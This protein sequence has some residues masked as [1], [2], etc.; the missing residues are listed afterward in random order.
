[1]RASLFSL[2]KEGKVGTRATNVITELVPWEENEKEA[3]KIQQSFIPQ[4]PFF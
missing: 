2:L 3:L 4:R 1:M